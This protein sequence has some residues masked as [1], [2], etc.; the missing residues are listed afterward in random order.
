MSLDGRVLAV[1]GGAGNVGPTV[2]RRLA[3][4]GALLSVAGRD[5]GPLE[6]L[7]AHV[8]KSVEPAVVDL[9][10]PNGTREWADRLNGGHG[11]GGGLV[12]L[13][14]GWGGRNAAEDSP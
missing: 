8:G 13:F 14:R 6:A 2:V 10:D 7:R 5:A 11:R 4:A 3:E 1:A 12:P 9:L